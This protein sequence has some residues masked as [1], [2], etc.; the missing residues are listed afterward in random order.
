MN[1]MEDGH[2]EKMYN[3]TVRGEEETKNLLIDFGER[4]PGLMKESNVD[5]IAE[6]LQGNSDRASIFTLLREKKQSE[7]KYDNR[8]NEALER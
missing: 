3:E 7:M 4:Y 2:F 8:N 6:V 1:V 5:K